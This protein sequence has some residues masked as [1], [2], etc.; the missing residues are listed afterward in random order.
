MILLHNELMLALLNLLVCGALVWTCVCRLNVMSGAGTLRTFRLKYVVLFTAAVAS[1]FS[2]VLFR[3][4]PTMTQIGISGA[5]LFVLG[6]GSKA[7]K[8]GVPQYA[9]SDPAPLGEP[10]LPFDEEDTRPMELDS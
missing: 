6:A 8:H 1:A 4:W 9:Q 3:E 5:F 10:E 2:P 7:W